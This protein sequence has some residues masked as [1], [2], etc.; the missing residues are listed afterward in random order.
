MTTPL[1]PVEEIRADIKRLLSLVA[2][3]IDRDG[4]SV[5][6]LAG[7]VESLENFRRAILA[8]CGSVVA[9]VMAAWAIVTAGPRPPLG[10]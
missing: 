4:R 2:G 5:P 9:A 10:H 7:R 1:D 3:G 8:V 6:G